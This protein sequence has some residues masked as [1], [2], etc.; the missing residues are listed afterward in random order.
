MSILMGEVGLIEQRL[1]HAIQ[2][3][4]AESLQ[5]LIG[6]IATAGAG[7]SVLGEENNPAIMH[8]ALRPYGRFWPALRWRAEALRDATMTGTGPDVH[9]VSAPCAWHY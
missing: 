4:G 2:T 7:A 3:G 1:N 8:A 9:G 6:A 5:I